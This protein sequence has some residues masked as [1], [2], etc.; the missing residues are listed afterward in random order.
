MAAVVQPRVRLGEEGVAAEREPL[1]PRGQLVPRVCDDE[2]RVGPTPQQ[3]MELRVGADARPAL[4]LLE[5]DASG[6][7]AVRHRTPL[8]A[9]AVEE[10]EGAAAFMPAQRQQRL[11]VAQVASASAVA[12]AH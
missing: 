3:R 10:E 12:A 9:A 6:E 8:H 5:V 2:A 4:V 11:D 7:L 1:V